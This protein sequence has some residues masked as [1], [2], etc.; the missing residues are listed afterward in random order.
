MGPLP[1]ARDSW[2]RSH[3]QVIILSDTFYQFADPLMQQLGRPTLFC[4][5]LVVEQTAL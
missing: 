2:M 1:G 5:R 3:A 4:H